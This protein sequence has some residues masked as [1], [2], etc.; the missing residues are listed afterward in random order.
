MFQKPSGMYIGENQPIAKKQR[1]KSTKGR[2]EK[3]EEKFIF[4]KAA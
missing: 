1:R 2:E 4:E 3:L